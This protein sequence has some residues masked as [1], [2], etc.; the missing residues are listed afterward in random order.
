MEYSEN[1]R[2]SRRLRGLGPSE[3]AVN[4][5]AIVY[6]A[7]TPRNGNAATSR[8]NSHD[9]NRNRVHHHGDRRYWSNPSRYT[10]AR[11]SGRRRRKDNDELSV[12]VLSLRKKFEDLRTR[13]IANSVQNNELAKE[14]TLHG[15][16]VNNND[17]VSTEEEKN[18][19]DSSDQ[20]S[21]Y[22]IPMNVESD[23]TVHKD[24]IEQPT[25][26]KTLT[27]KVSEL[28]SMGVPTH[29]A[30]NQKQ[31]RL[32]PY[33]PLANRKDA[34]ETT[35]DEGD[36]ESSS[37]SDGEDGKDT[38]DQTGWKREMKA[39][40]KAKYKAK[41]RRKYEKSESKP[42]SH[43]GNVESLHTIATVIS[44]CQRESKVV[45]PPLHGKQI[46]DAE[47]MLRWKQK[48]W[49]AT[50]EADAERA[51]GIPVDIPTP[52]QLIPSK[53]RSETAEQFACGVLNRTMEES[54]D[55]EL[56]QDLFH[57]WVL[58]VGKYDYM[59]EERIARLPQRDMI[60]GLRKITC[61]E[62]K[63]GQQ[64]ATLRDYFGKIEKYIRDNFIPVDDKKRYLIAMG[65]RV[66]L[67]LNRKD[68]SDGS[69]GMKSLPF[70]EMIRRDID[71]LEY[72]S[73]KEIE[74]DWNLFKFFCIK[75]AE[76]HDDVA[77]QLGEIDASE[78]PS[79]LSKSQRKRRAAKARKK[80]AA[81]AAVATSAAAN[82]DS[83]VNANGSDDWKKDIECHNCNKKG[84]FRREC[85][86]PKTLTCFHCGT[87]GHVAT[88]CP[89]LSDDDEKKK[90]N[91]PEWLSS[92]KMHENCLGDKRK[93][94]SRVHRMD[95]TTYGWKIHASK[96]ALSGD[97][98]L[99]EA[100]RLKMGLAD[101]V[102]TVT[103]GNNENIEVTAYLDDGAKDGNV[104]NTPTANAL[105]AKA[106]QSCKLV[107]C[108]PILMELAGGKT[109][110]SSEVW[111]T[112]QLLVKH[113]ETDIGTITDVVFDV[114]PGMSPE[115]ILGRPT[116]Q[117]LG[118]KSAKEQYAE[119]K[120]E[121][122]WVEDILD[123]DGVE[124]GGVGDAYNKRKHP[125]KKK[126]RGRNER[127]MKAKKRAELRKNVAKKI[128]DAA[129]DAHSNIK[130]P[131]VNAEDVEERLAADGTVYIGENGWRALAG[132]PYVGSD[133]IKQSLITTAA[134]AVVGSKN[135]E[136]TEAIKDATDLSKAQRV[137]FGIKDEVPTIA[138]IK[139]LLHVNDNR[140]RFDRVENA[141]FQ[142]V[143]SNVVMAVIG[144][145]TLETI[146]QNADGVHEVAAPQ[147]LKEAIA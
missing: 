128:L 24:G 65:K 104:A 34:G 40:L 139:T 120:K 133:S 118:I 69:Y 68:G 67:T 79:T 42:K 11:C 31:P 96:S 75:K 1:V 4:Q 130:K 132:V 78:T 47:V 49:H 110:A 116:L 70:R 7:A 112:Q 136:P 48:Y 77:R 105:A 16:K 92:N 91:L 80:K 36:S 21:Q 50:R 25:N 54:F 27:N 144:T 90:W 22:S 113:L 87:K 73:K 38:S 33:S 53:Y 88:E 5:L 86:E 115:I 145:D 140:Y 94:A 32:P 9:V 20:L 137:M 127:L 61:L 89:E 51:A 28:K 121:I 100:A 99:I 66:D 10:A 19:N 3:D 141:R 142:V 114:L 39:K 59:T 83:K 101:I 103:D 60:Q 124:N 52:L 76:V 6:P 146:E 37:V 102:C 35:D 45:F 108:E 29:L 93:R 43:H 2:R 117:K 109:D 23:V 74:N 107:E 56:I 106:P 71:K 82:A 147:H 30:I 126:Q 14:F 72:T 119:L 8:E 143:V 81:A 84:H 46:Y 13:N 111:I 131:E 138:A 125:S 97:P 85:K 15:A 58:G 95:A 129:K 134:L 57:D 135:F 98:K 62:T 12:K 63:K 55:I 17:E 41:Y 18:V 122:D 123:E 64:E 44:N 26:E